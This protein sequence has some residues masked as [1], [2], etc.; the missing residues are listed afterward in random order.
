MVMGRYRE[1]AAIYLKGLAMGSADAIPGV[2]GGTIALITGIYT[3]LI[4]ALTEIT[5]VKIF[6]LASSLLERDFSSSRETLIEMDILFLMVLASGVFSAL[7]LVLNFM[8]GLLANYPV[9]TYGFFF[10]LIGLSA[11][12]LYEEIDVTNRYRKL[13]AVAGFTV[14]FVASGYGAGSLGHSYTILFL[15]GMIAVSAMVLPGISGSLFLL[16]LGQYDFITGALSEF[17]SASLNFLKTGNLE[18][19][20]AA[21]PPIVV[22]VSGAFLGLF[23]VVHIVERALESHR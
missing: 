19:I 5:P 14:A 1:W 17:I 9:P 11:V 12:V 7:L 23:T 20:V 2:S 15:S 8:H 6:E 21:S 16:M 18:K 4:D 22:F 10:G 13:A 3:R